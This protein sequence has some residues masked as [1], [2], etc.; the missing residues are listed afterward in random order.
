M[1]LFINLQ[2]KST[3]SFKTTLMF[4]HLSFFLQSPNV[5]Q[6]KTTS[7]IYWNKLREQLREKNIDQ[8]FEASQYLSTWV[9]AFQMSS[10]IGGTGS[11]RNRPPGLQPDLPSGQLLATALDGPKL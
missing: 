2:S 1:T 4:L 7:E 3:F 9:R 6:K 8:L 5:L 10:I 11:A